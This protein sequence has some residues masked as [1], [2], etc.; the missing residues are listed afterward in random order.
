MITS[1]KNLGELKSEDSDQFSD[2]TSTSNLAPNAIHSSNSCSGPTMNP[3]S[4]LTPDANLS[5]KADVS[6]NSDTKTDSINVAHGG[7]NVCTISNSSSN[8]RLGEVEASSSRAVDVRSSSHSH[9]DSYSNKLNESSNNCVIADPSSDALSNLNPTV[10]AE[11]SLNC[12]QM[13]ESTSAD[14]RVNSTTAGTSNCS[15]DRELGLSGEKMSSVLNEKDNKGCKYDEK[16][17]D[18]IDESSMVKRKRNEKVVKETYIEK[19]VLDEKEIYVWKTSMEE[20]LQLYELPTL[21]PAKEFASSSE[22]EL[23]REPSLK[24]K[25]ISSS[26]SSVSVEPVGR[27]ALDML[28]DT[29]DEKRLNELLLKK[30][31]DLNQGEVAELEAHTARL[32]RNID[33]I[34]SFTS[35]SSSSLMSSSSG[36]RNNIEH[37]ALSALC[38]KVMIN[39]EQKKNEVGIN[40]ISS[41]GHAATKINC[42]TLIELCQTSRRRLTDVLKIF[43]ALMMLSLGKNVVNWIG[44]NLFGNCLW[45][46]QDAAIKQHPEISKMHGI[47]QTTDFTSNEPKNHTTQKPIR[48]NLSYVAVVEFLKLYLLGYDT[49]SVNDAADLIVLLNNYW[50]VTFR[51]YTSLSLLFCVLF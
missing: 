16:E 10:K 47:Q 34:N 42:A 35:S 17:D 29:K 20:Y 36:R 30:P 4:S 41:S 39:C 14:S 9:S 19:A 21:P 25:A 24:S 43:E 6:S 8:I 44:F 46:L 3:N 31:G 48:N 5:S 13:C 37:D 27:E 40:S 7:A 45:R 22:H 12:V 11:T 32:L 23:R 15:R 1:K 51:V 26:S 18:R 49:L 38:I 28:L 50:Y 2:T 33:N